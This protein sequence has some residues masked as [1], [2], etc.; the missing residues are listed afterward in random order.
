MAE[1]LVD[2][3]GGVSL[4][5][6]KTEY[7]VLVGAVLNV[8]MIVLDQFFNITLGEGVWTGLNTILGFILA[9]TLGSRMA[10][11]ETAAKAAQASQPGDVPASQ[12]NP[13]SGNMEN[14][15]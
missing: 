8:I 14:Q 13:Q 12:V 1:K 4:E 15:A 11:T 3:I 9:L 2:K 6:S 10:R 5:G 7:T